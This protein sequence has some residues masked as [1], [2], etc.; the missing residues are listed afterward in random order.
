[1]VATAYVENN[2]CIGNEMHIK[3]FRGDGALDWHLS[4]DVGKKICVLYL[5]LCCKFEGFQNKNTDNT[6][7]ERI[8]EDTPES[9]SSVGR[10]LVSNMKETLNFHCLP[11]ILLS[12][13]ML[14]IKNYIC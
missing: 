4:N 3:K 5:H 9:P 10:G 7:V 12:Y 14:P 1:M 11:F 8:W 2:L 13:L 6:Y